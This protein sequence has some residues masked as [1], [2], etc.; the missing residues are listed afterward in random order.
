MV[1]DFEMQ[2][3]LAQLDVQEY[4]HISA[5]YGGKHYPISLYVEGNTGVESGSDAHIELCEM[6]RSKLEEE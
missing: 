3:F 5:S 2:G 4:Q 6:F 1:D